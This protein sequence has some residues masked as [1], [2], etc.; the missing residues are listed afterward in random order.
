MDMR[1]LVYVDA[2]AAVIL[3]LCARRSR[4]AVRP[5]M[6]ILVAATGLA[7]CG[8]GKKAHLE[9]S[10]TLTGPVVSAP[11]PTGP[12]GGPQP[13]TA[14]TAGPSTTTTSTVPVAPVE[15]KPAAL[16]LAGKTVGID[17]GHNGLNYTDPPT[18]INHLVWNGRSQET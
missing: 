2:E 10:Q 12:Q 18:Y 13:G 15:P 16:P 14:S 17:P 3:F 1:P 4:R 9:R 8:T 11:E 5:I 6:W 7:A